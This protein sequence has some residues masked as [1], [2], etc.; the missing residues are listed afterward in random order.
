MTHGISL[1]S[2]ALFVTG[3]WERNGEDGTMDLSVRS[4]RPY[5]YK[6]HDIT[7]YVVWAISFLI[8]ECKGHL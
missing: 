6:V 2:R 1:P 8:R 5:S 7:R 4:M 3:Y